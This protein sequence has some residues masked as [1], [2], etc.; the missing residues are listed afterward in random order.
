[1]RIAIPTLI[2][3]AAALGTAAGTKVAG[4]AGALTGALVGAFL[5]ALAAGTIRN[6][7]VVIAP[8]RRVHLHFE[9]R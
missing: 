8:D 3:G 9:F 1:M 6:A 2:L 7:T 5:G 4:P